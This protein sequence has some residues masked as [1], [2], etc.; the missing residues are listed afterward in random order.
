MAAPIIERP[1]MRVVQTL[2][3]SKTYRQWEDW[4]VGDVVIGK[5][6]GKHKDNYGKTSPVI[7]V[8]Y[9]S[10]KGESAEKYMGKNLVLNS[11]AN[12]AN[13]LKE[14]GIINKD[15]DDVQLGKTIQ[16]EYTGKYTLEKG[17][18]KGKE[19]HDMQIQVVEVDDGSQVTE[20]QDV[21][22]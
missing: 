13:P 20:S 19:G 22:L 9:C 16:V 17:P 11:C 12:L 18:Y 4:A 21:D 6:V 1:K 10:F 3:V 14:A 8:D 5:I 15:G 7:L 2:T